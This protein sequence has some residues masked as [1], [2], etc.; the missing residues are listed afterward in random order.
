MMRPE[1]V[2]PLL[3]PPSY[4]GREEE[5]SPSHV[6]CFVCGTRAPWLVWDGGWREVCRRHFVILR[7]EY[8]SDEETPAS[9]HYDLHQAYMQYKEETEGQRERME[10]FWAS[11]KIKV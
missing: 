3:K 1:R 2:A 11:H 6:P 9:A 10:S 5:Y 7:H 4:R 8:L